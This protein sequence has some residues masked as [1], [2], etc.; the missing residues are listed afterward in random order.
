MILITDRTASDVALGTEKGQYGSGDLNRVEKAV[1]ELFALAAALDVE[2]TPEVKTD[3][4]FSELFS[5]SQWPTQAQMQRYLEN[6]KRLRDEL[7]V[8]VELPASMSRLDWRGANQIEQTLVAAE[9]RIRAVLQAFQFSG[10][11][12]AGEENGL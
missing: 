6:V 2:Y 8:V 4:S 10:E 5:S 9:R 1:E 11:I 12:F 3:W 7:G